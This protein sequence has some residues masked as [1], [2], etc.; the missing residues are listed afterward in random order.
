MNEDFDVNVKSTGENNTKINDDKDNKE[1]SFL[2]LFLG[3]LILLIFS[4]IVFP[5]VFDEFSFFWRSNSFYEPRGNLFNGLDIGK[6]VIIFFLLCIATSIFSCN[7]VKNHNNK[8]FESFDKRWLPEKGK[9]TSTIEYGD[10]LEMVTVSSYWLTTFRSLITQTIPMSLTVSFLLSVSMIFV[11]TSIIEIPV[12]ISIIFSSIL[13]LFINTV[14][15]MFS[16]LIAEWRRTR[17]KLVVFTTNYYVV[18]ARADLIQYIIN[19]EL[20]TAEQTRMDEVKEIRFARDPEDLKLGI[21]TSKF[22]E[23][24]LKKDP[25]ALSFYIASH[26]PGA[27]DVLLWMQDG[28]KLQKLLSSGQVE[29]EKINRARAIIEANAIELEYGDPSDKT[30]TRAKGQQAAQQY[31]DRLPKQKIVYDVY[32]A[33]DPNSNSDD[34]YSDNLPQKVEI[35]YDNVSRHFPKI[36]PLRR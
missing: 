21:K 23:L 26:R 34:E 10:K 8:I 28:Y 15:S 24:F 12:K 19:S 13:G 33:E 11:L 1:N 29:A 22:T 25:N 2:T 35:T 27:E 9:V 20:A 32:R 4:A 31:L 14:I 30:W 7:Y 18:K 16:C 5:W 36:N 17:S 3:I 6:F